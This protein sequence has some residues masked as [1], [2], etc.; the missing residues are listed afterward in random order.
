MKNIS[1]Q[2]YFLILPIIIIIEFKSIFDVATTK[3]SESIRH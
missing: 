1:I 2:L 3:Y